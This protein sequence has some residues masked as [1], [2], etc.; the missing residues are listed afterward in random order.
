VQALNKRH[1]K[2]VVF[3]VPVA[4]A[5]IALREKIAVGE[6]SGLKTQDDLFSDSIGHARPPIELLNAYC[7]FAVVYRRS[8]VGLEIKGAKDQKLHRLLQ[9]L[10]WDAVTKEP[11]SGVTIAP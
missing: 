4:Q 7:H 2:P 10:A 9:E 8:P 6:A 1:G 5:V 3:I 11:L